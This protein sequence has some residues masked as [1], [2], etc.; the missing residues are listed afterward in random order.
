MLWTVVL[1]LLTLYLYVMVTSF[2]NM[3]GSIE[4]VYEETKDQVSRDA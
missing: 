2:R 1:I 3:V 4:G